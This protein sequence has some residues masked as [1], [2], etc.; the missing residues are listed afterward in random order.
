VDPEQLRE[1]FQRELRA[2]QALRAQSQEHEPDWDAVEA[3]A[4]VHANEE[5]RAL[6]TM[7]ITL[8]RADAVA[9]RRL[10]NLEERMAVLCDRLLQIGEAVGELRQRV[11]SLE[12]RDER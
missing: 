2:I 9:G 12:Q 4:Q 5:T 7:M 11:E 10:Y 3:Q 6:L 8:G 1:T